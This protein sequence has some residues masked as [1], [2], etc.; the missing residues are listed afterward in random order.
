ML[1]PPCLSTPTWMDS[2][3]SASSIGNE[4][5]QNGRADA[6]RFQ[7]ITD[8]SYAQNGAGDNQLDTNAPRREEGANGRNLLIIRESSSRQLATISTRRHK[9]EM[10]SRA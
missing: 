6:T 4:D 1:N 8:L 9:E 7:L 5:T 3:E 10:V 2:C